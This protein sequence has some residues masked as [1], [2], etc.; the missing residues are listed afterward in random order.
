[1]YKRQ[2]QCLS[3]AKAK[4]SAARIPYVVPGP[5]DWDSRLNSVLA[6]IY[7]IFNAGYSAPDTGRDL[8]AE[9]LFLAAF[10]DDLCPVSYT[11]LPAAPIS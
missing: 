2:G 4:I 9:A 7:L 1:M 6:V 3:R 10:L 11:H 5:E 8:C